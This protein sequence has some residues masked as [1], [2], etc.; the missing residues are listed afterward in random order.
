MSPECDAARSVLLRHRRTSS[1]MPSLA[2]IN[3]VTLL[4]SDLDR[5]VCFYGEVFGARKLV[6]LPV[7]EPDGPGRHALIAIGAGAALHAFELSR[8]QPPRAQ[9]MFGRGRIDHFALQAADPEMFE[10]LRAVLIARSVTDGSVTDFGVVRV[11]TFTDPDGHAVELAHWIGATDP[12]EVD[13][14]RASDD[15]LIASRDRLRQERPDSLASAIESSP[16][17]DASPEL[18]GLRI[19]DAGPTETATLEALQRRS[20]D[21]WEQYRAQL[22]A[23]PDA[24]ELPQ[25]FID[26]RWVRV[27]VRADDVPIGFSAVIPSDGRTHELDGLFVEPG[28][29][30]H[31]VGRALI[32]DAASRARTAGAARLEVTVGPAQPFYERVGFTVSGTAQTRFGPAVRMRR[33]LQN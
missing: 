4:T 7:P 33:D 1:L 17:A 12:M 23:H 2:G 5:L 32:E 14:T 31:G 9:P 27:A 28:E 19:R 22:A 29:M 21:I 13:M 20:S 11:L 25:A 16:M 24:I 10:R 6:E 26:N 8:T 18:A 30:R 15:R 3:H